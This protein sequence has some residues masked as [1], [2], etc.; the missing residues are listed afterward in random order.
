MAK[1]RQDNEVAAKREGADWV[2]AGRRVG[3]RWATPAGLRTVRAPAPDARPAPAEDDDDEQ[4]D[5]SKKIKGETFSE[6]DIENLK[7]GWSFL[8]GLGYN[9]HY[10]RGWSY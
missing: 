5:I 6:G 10:E 9:R 1:W 3:P 4:E 2:G 7:C 8:P